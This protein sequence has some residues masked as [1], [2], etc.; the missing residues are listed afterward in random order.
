M[1]IFI[2]DVQTTF[3]RQSFNLFSHRDLPLWTCMGWYYPD[4]FWRPALVPADIKNYMNKCILIFCIP[5]QILLVEILS[6]DFCINILIS[7]GPLT[8]VQA[9]QARFVILYNFHRVSIYLAAVNCEHWAVNDNV[10]F[11]RF[12]VSLVCVWNRLQSQHYMSNILAKGSKI[13]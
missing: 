8:P 10:I 7:R 13:E 12:L 1:Y 11:V 6:W 5:I 9:E 4:A 2:F 3:Y